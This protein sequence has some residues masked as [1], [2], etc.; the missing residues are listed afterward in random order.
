MMMTNIKQKLQYKRMFET[1]NVRPYYTII[2]LGCFGPLL[3]EI[4]GWGY[5]DTI[6]VT[7]PDMNNTA[8]FSVEEMEQATKHFEEF[9]KNES[10]TKAL[11][12]NVR[13]RFKKTTKVEGRAWKQ[14]WS[15]KT[16]DALLDEMHSLQETLL[17][18]F[19]TMLISQPQHVLPLDEKINELLANHA[20]KDKALVA[21]THWEEDLPWA[22]EDREVEGLH[23]IWNT[24]SSDIQNKKIQQ[25]ADEYGWFNDIEGDKPFDAE[26]Y[27]QKIIDFKKEPRIKPD[28]EM[29]EEVKK[30]GALIAELGFLRFWNRYHFMTVRYHLKNILIEL[31]KKSKQPELAFATVDEINLFFKDKKIDIEEMSRRKNGYAAYLVDGATQIVTGQKAEELR[32]LVKEDFSGIQEIKGR[33]ANK[34]KATGKVRIISFVAKDYNK[35]VASF[36]QG[37]ILVTGMTRPQIVHLCKMAAAI[38]TDEG[39]ITSHAAVVSRE[40]GTPCIIATHNATKVLKTGDLVEVDANNGVVRKIN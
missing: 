40:F 31:V 5:E 4:T 19:S 7:S 2:H 28:V 38:V 8:Y 37:E 3:K 15:E 16:D 36:K 23:K 24:L 26:H 35:Q 1:R 12:N 33:I 18:T 25:L 20:Q 14:I 17:N 13:E 9:W 29:S 22:D 34:G 6:F 11:L 30:I 10:K 39:G 27:R 21:A 32:Q